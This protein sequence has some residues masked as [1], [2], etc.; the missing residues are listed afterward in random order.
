IRLAVP[1]VAHVGRVAGR[2]YAWSTAGAIAG[3]FA[4]GYVLL[5]ALG[6]DRTLLLVCLILTLTSL[7]VSKVWESNPMLYLFSIVLGGVC[8]GF[9]LTGRAERAPYLVA[10]LETNYYTIKVSEP[11]MFAPGR[12]SV[13]VLTLDALIH[14][15][16]DLDDP[17]FL[18]YEHEHIQVEFLW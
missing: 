7:A 13:R 8:G 1:D 16:V 12:T 18:H 2:V 15:E 3:T 11:R 17:R 6:M 9:I 5:S 10:K 14:S 4:A